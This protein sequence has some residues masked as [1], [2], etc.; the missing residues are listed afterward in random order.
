MAPAIKR[1]KVKE[2]AAADAARELYPDLPE[3][4]DP[5]DSIL[6]EMFAG[7]VAPVPDSTQQ[8]NPDQEPIDV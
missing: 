4:E 7:W 6:A 5:V 1:L 3:G 2:K 8:P